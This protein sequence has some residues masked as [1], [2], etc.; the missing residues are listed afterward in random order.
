MSKSI[1]ELSA[2][3][4]TTTSGAHHVF[5]L[6]YFLYYC[7]ICYM[8]WYT[9]LHSNATTPMVDDTA[10]NRTCHPRSTLKTRSFASLESCLAGRPSKRPRSAKNIKSVRFSRFEKVFNTYSPDEYDRRPVFC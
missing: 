6:F 3:P 2:T 10:D 7:M 1:I 4:S 8:L 9:A 5:S